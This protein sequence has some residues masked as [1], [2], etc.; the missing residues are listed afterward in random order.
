M[1]T[2]NDFGKKCLAQLKRFISQSQSRSLQA[3]TR[4]KIQTII[5]PFIQFD[6][7]ETVSKSIV[8]GLADIA[9]DVDSILNLFQDACYYFAKWINDMA[10]NKQIYNDEEDPR[11]IG[12]YDEALR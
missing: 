1:V 12:A 9:E 8:A 3:I 11:V 4:K 10:K 2:A 6:D 5:I 7:I